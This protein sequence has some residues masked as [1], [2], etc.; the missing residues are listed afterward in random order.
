[1]DT[2]WAAREMAGVTLWDRRCVSSLIRITAHLAARAGEAFSAACG[3]AGRQAAHRIFTAETTSV[4]GLLAG[5]RDQTVRRCRQHP[6]V[7]A[8]QD[9][10]ELDYTTHKATTG[11]GPIG[12]GTQ[13]GLLA[14]S[15]L[16]VTT[17]GIPLGLLDL[18]VWARDP[19]QAGQSEQRRK[20]PTA[21]KESQKWIDSLKAVEAALPPE[22]PV[23]VVSDREADLFAYLA[24]PRRSNTAL[25][26][27]AA[28]PRIVTVTE[29]DGSTTRLDLLTAARQG[30][31]VGQLTVTVPRQA[32]QREREAHLVVRRSRVVVQPPQ[33]R[34]ATEAD[35]P[36]EV[37][38]VCAVEA[39]VPAGERSIEWVLITTLAVRDGAAARRMV[40]YYA[41]RWRIERY[42]YTLKS[43]CKVE[44][45]QMET[46]ERLAKAL[47]VYAVVAWHLLWL[48]YVA[49]SDAEG[50]AEEVLEGEALQVLRAAAGRKIE[51]AREVVRGIGQMGGFEGAPSAGEP[52]VKVLW[53]GLRR[54]EAMVE[55]WLLAQPRAQRH[56]QPIPLLRLTRQE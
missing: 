6:L 4:R 36:Q 15:V 5:H 55:G 50:A 27:R 43:G 54:L 20:R 9:T 7:L 11:L 3:K 25:L 22:Q 45:L 47:S 33:H 41:L 32:G 23:V 53:L 1:M 42:H 35:T 2:T 49:R 8:L 40:R 44:Q 21:E 28:Q 10:T 52:G 24:A 34:L 13:R 12:K 31:I 14:H 17:E 19:Q 29:A 51:T 18:A 46:A 48:T 30:P 56:K 37:E 39:E 16:M 26:V 38:V